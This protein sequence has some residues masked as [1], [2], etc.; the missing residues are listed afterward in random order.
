MLR[1]RTPPV[2]MFFILVR[3]NA[4]P[5]PG[6]TNWKS[7]TTY[8][9]PSC[10][11]FTPF[12]M[13]LVSMGAFF[14]IVRAGGGAPPGPDGGVSQQLPLVQGVVPSRKSLLGG[15]GGAFSAAPDDGSG[16]KRPAG[17]P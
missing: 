17:G 7:T 1:S 4:W 13:S 16:Q 6:F 10:R 2:S 11:S 12:L 15:P 14:E 5:F 8:G 3:V 9:W